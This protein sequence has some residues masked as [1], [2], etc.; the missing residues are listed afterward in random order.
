MGYMHTWA[1]THTVG[2]GFVLLHAIRHLYIYSA[3]CARISKK[4]QNNNGNGKEKDKDNFL[5]SNKHTQFLAI[6]HVV[7][8]RMSDLTPNFDGAPYVIFEHV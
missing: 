7:L 1:S 2:G 3:L 8:S 4:L 5:C 6:Y